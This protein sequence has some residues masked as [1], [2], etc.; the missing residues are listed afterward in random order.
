MGDRKCKN[1]LFIESKIVTV[2]TSLLKDCTFK[3]LQ[4][5]VLEPTVLLISLVMLSELILL[6]KKNCCHRSLLQNALTSSREKTG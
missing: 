5:F 6:L 4:L 1:V 2:N 3:R